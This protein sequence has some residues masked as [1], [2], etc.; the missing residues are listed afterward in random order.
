MS[1]KV[2][3]ARMSISLCARRDGTGA[4]IYVGG[5][6]VGTIH[7]GRLQLDVK[8]APDWLTA[9]LT[10]RGIAVGTLPT[11]RPGAKGRG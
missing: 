3:A 6:R 1:G 8:R 5:Q 2:R 7:R 11:I 4:D 10:E 9:R